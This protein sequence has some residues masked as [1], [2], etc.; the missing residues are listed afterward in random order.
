MYDPYD[1]FNMLLR[2]EQCAMKIFFVDAKKKKE[3]IWS[4]IK[5]SSIYLENIHFYTY[6]KF[7]AICR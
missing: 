6:S 5:I 4:K 2:I 1:V 7:K 3:S